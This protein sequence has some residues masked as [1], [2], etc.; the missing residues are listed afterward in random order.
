MLAVRD[1]SAKRL[2]WGTVT[3]EQLASEIAE[4]INRVAA[5][6]DSDLAVT[7]ADTQLE[8]PRNRDHGDWASNSAMKFAKRIGANPRDLASEISARL[9]EIDGV[10]KAE[11]AGPG[12]INITLQAAAAGEIAR[13]IVEQGKSYGHNTSLAGEVINLEFVSANPTGPLHL[14]HTRWAA[15]G[16]S[17]SRLLRAAGAKV[18]NEFYINDAGAQMEKFGRSVRAAALGEPAPEDAYPGARRRR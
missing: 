9:A 17:L 11:I 18:T 3:P 13:T 5:K 14:G 1:D 8:R 10:E 16:D 12:F 15:L 2:E 6:H 4:I 7:A